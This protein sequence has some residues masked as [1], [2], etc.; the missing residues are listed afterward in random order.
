MKALTVAALLMAV[1]GVA[2]A[3]DAPKANPYTGWTNWQWKD[4]NFFPITVWLQGVKNA[5]KYKAA[6][7]NIYVGIFSG[8]KYEDLA[9]YEKAGMAVICSQTD[10]RRRISR[11]LAIARSMTATCSGVMV[12]WTV[13]PSWQWCHWK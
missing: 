9:A 11:W 8:P 4:A 3:A 2:L 10:R 5:E 12:L 13:R 7:I 1:A 6:G